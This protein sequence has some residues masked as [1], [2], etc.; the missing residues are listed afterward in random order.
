M[1]ADR[2]ARRARRARPHRGARRARRPGRPGAGRPTAGATPRDFDAQAR[3]VVVDSRAARV[4]EP[5]AALDARRR[6][7]WP[8]STSRCSGG[9]DHLLVGT[10]LPFL[11]APGLHHVEAFSEALAQ[12][13]WGEA[14]GAVR[15]VAAAG[16]RPRALGGVPGGL[17]RRGRDDARGGRGRPR[18]GAADDHLPLRRRAPQLRRGGL[19]RP[20][21]RASA[22]RAGSCRR[23]A[24]RSATRCRGS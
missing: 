18:P 9:V 17:P 8:G 21:A 1:A 20:G 3:L 5:D 4:L 7:S 23:C 6:A 11:L 22:S 16:R 24:R 19:A 14:G 12:G 2:D 10:S 13:A 15:R